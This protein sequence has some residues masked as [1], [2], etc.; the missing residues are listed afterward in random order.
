LNSW[1]VQLARRQNDTISACDCSTYPNDLLSAYN[2]QKVD[3][4]ISAPKRPRTVHLSYSSATTVSTNAS[5]LTNPHPTGRNS[6][7]SSLT[8][9]DID[10]LFERITIYAIGLIC[11]WFS[12]EELDTKMQQFCD[13][14]LSIRDSLNTSISDLS[15]RLQTMT[16]KKEMP[17]SIILGMENSF[18]E[19]IADFSLKLAL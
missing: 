8:D 18:K 12:V 15:T 17:N 5:G 13:K 6:T 14:V 3:S 10:A 7:I 19:S 4:N 9:K 2:R 16:T 11:I 1:R